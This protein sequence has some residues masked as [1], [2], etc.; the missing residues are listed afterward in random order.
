MKFFDLH[1]DI[2][3]DLTNRRLNGHDDTFNSRHYAKMKT[4][5]IGGAIFVVWNDIQSKIQ[6]ADFLNHAFDQIQREMHDPSTHMKVV[7]DSCALNEKWYDDDVSVIVGIE[8]IEAF[9]DS[10]MLLDD[11]Y[12]KGLRHV[13]LTWNEQNAFATGVNGDSGR[14]LTLL[15]RKMVLK[16]QDRNMILD[17]AHLNERSF[18]D[19]LRCSCKP[20]MVSH[21]NAYALCPHKRNLKDEQIKAVSAQGGI[22]GVTSVGSFL[23]QDMS[24]RNLEVFVEHIAHMVDVGGIETVALGFDFCDYIHEN[25][26]GVEDFEDVSKT[27][28]LIRALSKKG[29]TPPEI[30]KMAYGNAFRFIKSTGF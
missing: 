25:Y 6:P 14:G 29:F 23:S 2:F 21:S 12:E 11:Y 15:G 30:E 27:M 9:G 19:V 16:I 1:A 24:N 4:G 5:H 13:G 28:N 22:I 18:W 20:I 10:I 8:G 17:L 3:Y 7:L 26:M